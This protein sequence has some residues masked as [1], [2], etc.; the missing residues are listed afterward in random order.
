[1]PF[2]GTISGIVGKNGVGKSNVLL[3]IEWMARTAVSTAEIEL[4]FYSPPKNPFEV[5]ARI[6]LE[7]HSYEYF[8]QYQHSVFPPR[9]GAQYSDRNKLVE[10]L[11][12]VDDDAEPTVLF[13][14]VDDTIISPLRNDPLLVRGTAPAMATITSLLP[15]GDALSGAIE[16]VRTF[17][18]GVQYYLIDDRQDLNRD[19]VLDSEYQKWRQRYVTEGALTQSVA[20][21]LLYM[22]LEDRPMLEEFRSLLGA[23]G[24]GIVDFVG[25][26]TIDAPEGA[27]GGQAGTKIH[28]FQFRPL[29]G[30]GGSG[31][32]RGFSA[33]SSGT[34]RAIRLLVSILFDRRSLMLVEEPEVSIH[35]GLLRKLVDIFRSYS[36]QSQVVFTTHSAEVLNM[37]AAAEIVLLSAPEGNTAARILSEEEI[38][39]AQQFLREDGSLSDYFE[40]LDEYAS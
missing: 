37:L 1:V 24:L 8:I 40:T 32:A 31:V 36:Q 39:L 3:A 21:R 18:E 9:P 22:W 4:P 15:Q 14:R 5:T 13:D 26:D 2:V 38:A 35:P 27:A 10:R 30:M 33:L 11:T 23:S 6:E 19:L 17:F 29:Q 16:P 28:F 7:E 34:R 25:I 12:L 20:Y